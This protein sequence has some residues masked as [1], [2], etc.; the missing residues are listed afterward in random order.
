METNGNARANG[1]NVK[2]VHTH[3]EREQHFSR[4]FI[5]YVRRWF[6]ANVIF[7]RRHSR[8]DFGFNF[9]FAALAGC[10]WLRMWLS[11]TRNRNCFAQFCCWCGLK[12]DSVVINTPHVCSLKYYETSIDYLGRIL[13][14]RQIILP[15]SVVCGWKIDLQQLWLHGFQPTHCF[16]IPLPMVATILYAIFF[17]MELNSNERKWKYAPM[18]QL[19]RRV[20]FQTH[21]E[22]ESRTPNGNPMCSRR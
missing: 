15:Y 3:A 2:K 17:P 20:I 12:Y 19:T 18:F 10:V 6:T 16:I 7:T 4:D 8:N 13:L 1:S 11:M 22:S 5:A 21:K 9:G 14:L